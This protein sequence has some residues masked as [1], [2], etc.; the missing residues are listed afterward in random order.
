M[1]IR[2]TCLEVSGTS[3]RLACAKQIELAQQL[4]D[5]GSHLFALA[6]QIVQLLGEMLDLLAQF[7]ALVLE[8][9]SSRLKFAACAMGRFQLIL[10]GLEPLLYLQILVAQTCNDLYRAR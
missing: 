4:F 8:L 7:I 9:L 5:P 6:T 1:V 3:I 2:T 10:Y